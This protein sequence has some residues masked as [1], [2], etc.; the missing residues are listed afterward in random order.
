MDRMTV[1]GR[2]LSFFI[3]L[4]C[5]PAALV[6]LAVGCHSAGESSAPRVPVTI[7]P[8]VA[9]GELD[10][11]YI[12][13][14]LDTAQITGG[15]WWSVG[16]DERRPARTPDLESPKLRRLAAALAP[17]TL[18]IGGTD[19]DGAYFCPDEGD[20]ELPPSYRE[21]FLDRENRRASFFTHEDIRRVADFAEAVG[22]TVLF[23]LNMGSGPRDPV[24]GAWT[25]DN[26]RALI[27]YARSL[28]N[29]HV[30]DVWE[31]GNE[32]N[33]ISYHFDVP[34]WITPQRFACDLVTLRALV[35]EEDPGAP[36]SAPGSY[37]HPFWEIGNFTPRL[38]PLVGDTVDIL[39]WHLYATQSERCGEEGLVY[40]PFP[41]TRENLFDEAVIARHRRFARGVVAAGRGLPVWNGESASAQCG[42]QRGVSD[43]LLDALWTAD[44]LGVMAE[45]GSRRVIRQTLVGSDYGVIDPH[46]YDPRPTLLALALYRRTVARYRLETTV[47]RTRIKAHGFC[48]AGMDGRVTAVL[49]NPTDE[50]IIAEVDLVGT[51]VVTA[52]RWTLAAGG[53]LKA[54]RASIQGEGARADGSIPNP[55]GTPV[56]VEDGVAYPELEPNTVGFVVL[57][58][59]EGAPVCEE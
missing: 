51:R 39:T 24:S 57:E 47:D 48:A 9:A 8:A 17:S 4:G 10:E 55:P 50:R 3:L 56:H 7:D 54:T 31:A 34:V 42:G 2:V 19:C 11:R 33:V 26:A 32:V 5:T 53:D 46:T 14:A 40:R 38:M 30:F 20:C 27:R 13:F 43:T 41:A 16:V 23:C 6:P 45:E 36:I 15:K 35:D 37:I 52:T 44:W 1:V 59:L 21:A 22:A 49:V 18:R 29:G 58:P 12:G 25:S 28:P